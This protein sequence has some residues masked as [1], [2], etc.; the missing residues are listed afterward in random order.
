MKTKTN[1]I[2]I[3]IVMILINTIT[4]HVQVYAQGNNEK[5]ILVKSLKSEDPTSKSF[6]IAVNQ[7]RTITIG[8]SPEN[9]SNKKLSWKT[10]NSKIATVSSSGRVKG[11]K[12]GTCTITATTCDGSKKSI[13][14]TVTVKKR[15]TRYKF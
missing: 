8:V 5:V 14:Y 12:V 10:S 9:A 6:S 15:K 3:L 1:I 2:I 4:L 13:K 11:I 7:S